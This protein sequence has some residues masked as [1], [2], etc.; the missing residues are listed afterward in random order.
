MKAVTFNVRCDNPYDG[1]QNIKFRLPLI[2][3]KINTVKPDIIGFQEVQP[4]ISLKIKAMLPDYNV[5]GHG[6]SETYESE[7]TAIAYRKERFDLIS[8]DTFWLSP[9]PKVPGSRYKDQSVCPR[10]CTCVTLF[11]L[12]K[13][14]KIRVYNTHLDHIGVSARKRGLEL[15][16]KRMHKDYERDGVKYILMGDFNA[17]PDSPE[18]SP[19]ET[20]FLKD[21]TVG[22]GGTYHGYGT[23]SE[24]ID[25]ILAGPAEY[26][27]GAS[28]PVLWKDMQGSLYISD[29]HA[30]E[31]DLP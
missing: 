8:Y 1:D 3:K 27:A 11:D 28:A 2:E 20:D 15:I 29:H 25:Y 4:H 9:T 10:N 21:L 17:F 7:H 5:L 30:V 19:L 12:E 18:L 14:E 26:A 22:T 23:T 6:R 24:K 16:L 13:H 31:V